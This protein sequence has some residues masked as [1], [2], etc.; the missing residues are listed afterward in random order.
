M[1]E[2]DTTV[3]TA[4]AGDEDSGAVADDDT[5]AVDHLDDVE[6]GAGCTEIWEHLSDRR[7]EE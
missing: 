4:D 1:S 3:Q 6:D 5:V 7:A 2:P